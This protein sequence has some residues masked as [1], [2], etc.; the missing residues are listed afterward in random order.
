[1]LVSMM[2]KR[3]AVGG[4]L[5]SDVSNLGLWLKA[6]QGLTLVGSKVS[7][8]DDLSGN[9]RHF[10][11]SNDTYRPTYE[12]TGLDGYPTVY[13][14]AA[15]ILARASDSLI[16]NVNGATILAVYKSS[17]TPAAGQ[18][19]FYFSNNVTDQRI[20]SWQVGSSTTGQVYG[21]RL[22]AD[23]ATASDSATGYFATNVAHVYGWIPD[24]ANADLFMRK[25]GTQVVG[26]TSW[27]TTGYTSDT[28]SSVL[29]IG[30][31]GA[32]S[33]PTQGRLSEF[34]VYQRKL[35][36]GEF[37]SVEGYLGDEYGIT[38]A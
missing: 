37:A 24:W 30:G 1:M 3:H 23:G 14:N 27:L 28:N 8:W 17:G 15:H 11:Q 10:S 35:D 19:L 7:Q 32:L 5:P 6:N 34:L 29:E 4:F 9:S 18:C 16:R 31:H 20:N 22:D 26:D 25:D 21:R 2:G 13:F 33:W 12:A 38:V 36:A